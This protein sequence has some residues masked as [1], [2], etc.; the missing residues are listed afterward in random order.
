MLRGQVDDD[1][2]WALGGVAPHAGLFSRGDDV[3]RFGEA[4][5][6]A[7]AGERVGPFRPETVQRFLTLDT[8][9]A[10]STRALGW[11][12]P[13]A[14]RSAAGTR[15]SRG[16]TFGH[17]GFTG[18]SLWLDLP[19]QLCVVLLTNRIHCSEDPEPIRVLRA[20]VHDLVVASL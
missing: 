20:E 13:R 11:D 14:N 3:A 5:V 6:R 18:C 19:R 10:G 7:H 16:A 2:A 17:L 1:N 15:M 8:A 4:I 12:T 9:T